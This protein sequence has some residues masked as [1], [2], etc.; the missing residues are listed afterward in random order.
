MQVFADSDQTVGILKHIRDQNIYIIADCESAATILPS[1]SHYERPPSHK[2]VMR[3]DNY[4]VT[5]DKI[6]LPVEPRKVSVPRNFDMVL[7]T[8]D[9]VRNAVKENGRITVVLPCFPSARQDRRGGRY[10]LDLKRRFVQLEALGADHVLTLDIHNE[11]TQLAVPYRMGYDPLYAR[12]SIV[13]HIKKRGIPDNLEIV[14]P[15]EGAYKKIAKKYAKDLGAH[16][17]FVDKARSDANKIESIGAGIGKLDLEGKNIYMTDDMIDTAGTTCD[18][19][20]FMRECGAASVTAIA[21][22]P[23][24]SPPAVSRLEDAVA[25]GWIREVIV[26][27]SVTLPDDIKA[28]PWLT[29]VDVTKYFAKAIDLM[30]A[31]DSISELLDKV[32]EE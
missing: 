31:G 5:H 24:F 27:N 8:L 22:H 11:S 19:A 3:Q 16:A 6:I 18:A 21:A 20:R 29:T 10:S 7:S 28:K 26:T 17:S 25:N 13:D 23:I 1:E 2:I 4:E 32:E 14:S 9:A 12:K 30:N 15:D